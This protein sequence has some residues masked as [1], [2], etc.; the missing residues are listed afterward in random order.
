MNKKPILI[1]AGE[2]Y[3][4]FSEIFFKSLN[5]INLKRPIVLIASKKLFINQMKK[6]GY[7]FN[8]T[9]INKDLSN[10]IFINK[11]IINI[12]NVDFN[13]NKTFDKISDRSNN[14]INKSFLLANNLLKNKK[15]YA[16]INGPISKKNFLKTK[17]SGITEYLAEMNKTKNYTMLIYNKSLSV[18][19]ITTHVALKKVSSA[20]SKKKILNHVYLI[21][22]FY[23]FFF[24]K[25]INIAITGL[26]PHCE[27][28]FQDS[29]EKSIIYPAIKDL[30]KKKYK[31]EGPLPADSLFMK[32]NIKKFDVVI[33]MYHDQVLTPIK[34][35]Y[36]FD[37]I[38]ITLGLPF[39][40]ISPDHGTNNKMLGKN[41]SNATS[42]IKAIKFLNN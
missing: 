35:I 38:N 36:N 12:I 25:N 37:A 2:P 28:N 31:I 27:S 7:K 41:K 34:T 15:A 9:E 14:Y 42:L 26:N 6:L 32:D 4:I 16:L 40:R 20:I 18:S 22:K 11:K 13:F 21:K 1:V 3:S 24:N 33:G 29:E 30:K 5:Y 23:K 8:F 19:P 39:I 17:F 10:N